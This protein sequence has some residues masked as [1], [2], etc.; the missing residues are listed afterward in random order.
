[1]RTR[2]DG[3]SP[4]RPAARLATAKRWSRSSSADPLRLCCKRDYRR[5]DERPIKSLLIDR[6]KIGTKSRVAGSHTLGAGF[7]WKNLTLT[8]AILQAEAIVVPAR[9][10]RAETTRPPMVA[11]Q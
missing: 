3:R 10:L 9:D 6:G 2:A 1:M 8:F 11:R 7:Q 4:D 5:T